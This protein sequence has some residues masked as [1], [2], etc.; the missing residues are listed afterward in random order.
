M[1]EYDRIVLWADYF[2][3]NIS[4]SAGRRVGLSSATKLPTLDELAESG[5]RLG[6]QVEV[7]TAS[8]PRRSPAK[9]GYLSIPRTKTKTQVINAIG[10]MLRQIRSD[11]AHL[12]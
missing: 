6:Y 12:S 1:K 2:D 5:R 8:H 4:R 7:V 11:K 10:E 9:S 3:S